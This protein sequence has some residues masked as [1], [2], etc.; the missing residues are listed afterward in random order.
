MR[1][2][3]PARPR[4]D[5]FSLLE[6][7]VALTVFAICAM[8]LFG[9]MTVNQSALARVQARDAS[10]RDGR[11]AL[12]VLESVNPMEEPQGRR[13]LPGG[14]EVQWDGTELV[15]RAAGMGPSGN[16]VVF[17]LALYELDVRAVRDGRE[18]ARFGLRRAGWE[19]VRTLHDEDF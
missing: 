18:V 5:G 3:R 19:T 6:A 7:I 13:E 2:R 1:R 17:D 11:A 15:P 14:L 8:A 16:T 9:W 4:A 10:V 12:A